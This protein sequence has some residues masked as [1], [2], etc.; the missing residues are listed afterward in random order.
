MGISTAVGLK[1]VF[2]LSTSGA[3]DFSVVAAVHAE[4]EP[5]EGPEAAEKTDTPSVGGTSCSLSPGTHSVKSAHGT[6]HGG[7]LLDD[8]NFVWVMGENTLVDVGHGLLPG[9]H[10][11]LSSIIWWWHVVIEA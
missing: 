6:G 10:G 1:N 9:H 11:L 7:V 5:E 8:D 2:D 4:R 3:D